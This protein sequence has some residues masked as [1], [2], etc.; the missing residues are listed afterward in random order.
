MSAAILTEEDEAQQRKAWAAE[1]YRGL[2]AM[3]YAARNSAL[4]KHLGPK[5]ELS[6]EWKVALVSRAFHERAAL[7]W[8]LENLEGVMLKRIVGWMGFKLTPQ[9]VTKHLIKNKNFDAE[10][11]GV[12]IRSRIN[13]H[14][15][16]SEETCEATITSIDDKFFTP[17]VLIDLFSM[18]DNG[19]V[20]EEVVANKAKEIYDMPQETPNSWVRKTLGIEQW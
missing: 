5:S 6:Y 18:V 12:I 19:F 2:Q 16:V 8:G 3:K 14:S 9:M 4:K 15:G 1:T 11:L 17:E 7:L 20:Q 13:P 10:V